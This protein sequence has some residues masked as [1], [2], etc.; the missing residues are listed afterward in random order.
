MELKA[1]LLLSSPRILWRSAQQGKEETFLS[2]KNCLQDA[3]REHGSRARQCVR[4]SCRGE[5]LGREVPG[6]EA[7]DARTRSFTLTL[8]IYQRRDG[9][10]PTSCR[11][12]W[13]SWNLSLSLPLFF[14]FFCLSRA[15]PEACVVSQARGLIGAMTAGLHHSH[16]NARSETRLHPTPQL[17]ATPDP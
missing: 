6:K 16:S 8:Q 2:R 3:S 5:T 13:G 11:V 10:S 1:S 17:M 7:S 9:V 15:A 4:R 14:F 12:R